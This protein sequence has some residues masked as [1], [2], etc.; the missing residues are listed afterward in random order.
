MEGTLI[1]DA[2]AMYQELPV[3]QPVQAK[4]STM[5]NQLQSQ[6]SRP[7]ETFEAT[8]PVI[9]APIPTP[10]PQVQRHQPVQQSYIQPTNSVGYID[11]M[12]NRRRDVLKLTAISVVI[13][14]AISFHYV[15]E[16][17]LK[18]II[19]SSDFSFKQELGIRFLYPVG[20][21]LLLWNIKALTGFK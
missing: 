19:I 11:V 9:Q 5:I 7:E 10:V 12:V 17:F 6:V 15:V 21:F 4:K 1:N 8:K 2:F 20:V 14:L 13:L 3:Q 18:E 16:F